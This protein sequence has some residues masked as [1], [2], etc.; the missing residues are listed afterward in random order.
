[1]GQGVQ[2][3]LQYR[4]R[5]SRYATIDIEEEANA[6]VNASGLP[7]RCGARLLARQFLKDRNGA[8]RSAEL[9]S[10]LRRNR[11]ME[12]KSLP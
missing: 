11:C 9:V 7:S 1:M 12:A 8:P 3:P 4:E 6:R 2:N 5:S 10:E